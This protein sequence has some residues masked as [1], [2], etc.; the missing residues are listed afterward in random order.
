[1]ECLPNLGAL[2]G[3]V[4]VSYST[5]ML[6]EFVMYYDGA[7]ISPKLEGA[8]GGLQWI[9]SKCLSSHVGPFASCQS[10]PGVNE[11]GSQI[12]TVEYS[13]IGGY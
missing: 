12:L 6:S 8:E 9:D 5:P 2:D 10:R 4:T 1:M 11:S 13:A 3:I 7:N